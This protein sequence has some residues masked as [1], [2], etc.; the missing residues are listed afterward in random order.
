MICRVP[1]E[2]DLRARVGGAQL[3]DRPPAPHIQPLSRTEAETSASKPSVA[4][5]VHFAC[6]FW[7]WAKAAWEPCSPMSVRLARMFLDRRALGLRPAKRRSASGGGNLVAAT[8]VHGQP[9]DRVPFLGDRKGCGTVGCRLRHR[10]RR[11]L[12]ETG[13]FTQNVHLSRRRKPKRLSRLGRAA[14]KSGRCT[15]RRYSSS[16][17]LAAGTPA[18]LA[19]ISNASR[20]GKSMLPLPSWSR[21]PQPRGMPPPVPVKQAWSWAKSA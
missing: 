19:Q 15:G 4:T 20:S 17:A 11:P 14:C 18:P 1:V 6:V 2:T 9:D 12:A 21:H 13:A 10:P 16:Q 5:G 7:L 8:G 3:P